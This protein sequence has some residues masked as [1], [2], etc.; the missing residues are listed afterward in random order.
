M[1]FS[2]CRL[3]FEHLNVAVNGWGWA[4]M[5][6]FWM[7]SRAYVMSSDG[8]A[9]WKRLATTDLGH[10]SKKSTT[11]NQKIFWVQARRLVDPFEPL[12]SSLAQGFSNF[13]VLLPHFKKVF[14]RRPLDSLHVNDKWKHPISLQ[15]HLYQVCQANLFRDP[16]IIFHDPK[17]GCDP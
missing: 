13:F 14:S 5:S 12:N 7:G 15:K 10:H 8:V 1:C 3:L 6:Y 9:R 2:S 11:P 16:K 4:T 17:W